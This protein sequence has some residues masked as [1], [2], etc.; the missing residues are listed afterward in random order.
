MKH[1]LVSL[2][3]VFF[4]LSPFTVHAVQIQKIES[5]GVYV[6]ADKGYV[7]VTPYDHMD[8]FV[9]FKYLHEITGVKRKSDELKLVVYDKDFSPG[10]YALELRPVQTTIDVRNIGFSARPL[11]QKDMYELTADKPVRNGMMLHVRSYSFFQNMGVVMLGDVET[12][13]VNYFSQKNLP[14]AW[15]VEQYLDDALI[16]FPKSAKLKQLQPHWQQAARAEK[17]AKAYGYVDE[18]WRKYKETD[19]ISLK[20]RYLRD[21]IGEVNAYL[22]DFPDGKKAAEALERKGYAE[23]KLPE[24]EKQL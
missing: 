17:D 1:L 15:A 19:K 22:R 3:F 18:Q 16:A 6:V 21:M 13:L 9:D 12:E 11:G 4:Q 10:N 24:Y 8:N 14:N 7:R 5:Y 23:K 2:I 20:A